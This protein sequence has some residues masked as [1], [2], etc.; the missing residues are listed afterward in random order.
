M[1]APTL[2][3]KTRWVPR[4]AQRGA[5]RSQRV[6]NVVTA[7]GPQVGG[8]NHRI[9]AVERAGDRAVVVYVDRNLAVGD[10]I[11]IDRDDGSGRIADESDRNQLMTDESFED[12]LAYR[13]VGS[14]YQDS[15]HGAAPY[16]TGSLQTTLALV[17]E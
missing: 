17:G 10:R 7:A 14:C 9:D 5:E 1:S 2:D 11:V 4:S 8:V 13:A 6:R 12:C 15:A 16:R 3:R